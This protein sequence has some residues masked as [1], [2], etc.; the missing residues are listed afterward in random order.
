MYKRKL[1]LWGKF[2]PLTIFTKEI[3]MTQLGG[4]QFDFLSYPFFIIAF[5]YFLF[6]RKLSISKKEGIVFS[7]I[8]SQ[9]ILIDLIFDLPLILFFKQFLPIIIMYFSIKYIFLSNDIKLIF[10]KYVDYAIIVAFIGI[11]QFILKFFGI[12]LLTDYSGFFIDSVALEPSHYVIMIL[13]SVLYFYLKKDFSWRFWLLFITII[14]TFKLTGLLS[15]IMFIL[16]INIKKYLKFIIIGIPLI[17][18]SI[19]I[20]NSIP[21]FSNRIDSALTYIE[22]GDIHDINNMT[23]FSFLSNSE[24]AKENFINTYGLGIGLGGHETTYIRNFSLNK[25]QKHW[26]GLNSKS[27]HSLSLR[28]ISELG[29]LGVFIFFMLFYKSFKIKHL[30]YSTIAFASLSHFIAKS[31]KLGSYFD[32]GTIFFLIVII[33]SITKDKKI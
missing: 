17:Y 31:F 1:N 24:V 25:I 10:Q 26:Y 13:P 27:A 32:Y 29:I 30:A 22:S 18:S 15:I 14:L 21:E 7:I 6:N 19:Y 28:I 20:I 8:L 16:I 5:V 33:I 3:G 4:I 11:I 12:L 2:L 23:T 9:G